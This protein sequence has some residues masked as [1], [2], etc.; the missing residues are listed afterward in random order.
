M[1][2]E[3]DRFIGGS[4]E[5]KHPTGGL[6]IEFHE[7]DDSDEVTSIIEIPASEIETVT[8]EIGYWRKANAI[9]KWF[10][11]NVQDGKDECQ[12]SYVTRKQL[13]QLRD[14]CQRVLDSVKVRDGDC[15]ASTMYKAD[16]TVENKFVPGRV[17]TNPGVCAELLPTISGFFFGAV[18]Y[19]EWYLKDLEKTIE[20]L[21][22]VPS[23]G[24]LY[25]RA[26]W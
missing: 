24:D 25:Y 6:K 12:R 11:D 4:W 10:V 7:E 23:W 13:Q 2:L 16:G 19:N 5:F 22:K 17:V 8:T 18:E 20:I 1:Y 21:D 14:L 26:S 9:H 15:L 3:A